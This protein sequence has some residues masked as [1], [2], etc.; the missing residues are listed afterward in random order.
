MPTTSFS[1]AT[2]IARSAID[3]L[4]LLGAAASAALLLTLRYRFA[5]MANAQILCALGARPLFAG[6]GVTVAEG[7]AAGLNAA[8]VALIY[9]AA[10]HLVRRRGWRTLLPRAVHTCLITVSMV[11][12]LLVIGG[13][14][15]HR[16]RATPGQ[17]AGKHGNQ[18]LQQIG[19]H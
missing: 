16:C 11:M 3:T 13:S 17:P 1:P 15:Q 6:S 5:A 9:V 7:L 12:T 10:Q 14:H 19:P 8:K 2:T 18:V 4:I